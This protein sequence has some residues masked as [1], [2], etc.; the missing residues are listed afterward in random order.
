MKGSLWKFMTAL[1]AFLLVASVLSFFILRSG[2][3]SR[4][5]P[6]FIPE[7]M[8]PENIGEHPWVTGT[9]LEPE[10]PDW[11]EDVSPNDF[12]TVAADSV[13]KATE[14]LE[15]TPII[16]LNPEAVAFYT[17]KPVPDAK[18]G[19]FFLLRGVSFERYHGRFSIKYKASSVYVCFG[20]LG[21]SMPKLTKTPVVVRLPSP[22]RELYVDYFVAR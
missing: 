16:T 6:K 14:L 22:P 4:R 8:P 21:I 18:N 20:S 13:S 15:H 11:W 7:P 3:S 5:D 17:G 2:P 19:Q 1:I 10:H 9:P 12:W